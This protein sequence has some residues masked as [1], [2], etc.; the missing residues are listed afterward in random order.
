MSPYFL[1][2]YVE[3]R[4]EEIERQTADRRRFADAARAWDPN[5]PA[6]PRGAAR[7]PFSFRLRLLRRE[8]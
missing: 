6:A 1:E 4:R 7:S 2:R 3:L 8:S 5:E